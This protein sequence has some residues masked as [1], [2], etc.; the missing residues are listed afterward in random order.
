MID[1]LV[2]FVKMSGSGNDFIMIDNRA[3]LLDPD[4]LG[5]WIRAVCRRGVAVGA[6]GV[7]LVQND[8][9]GEVDFAWRFFN[10]DGGEAEMCGNGGRCV[11]RWAH[12]LGLAS[13]QTA[14]RTQVGVIRGWV[15]GGREVRVQLTEP[16]DYRA[17]VSLALPTGAI[18]AA[19]LDTGVPHAVLEVADAQAVD[20]AT[21]GRAIRM[22]DAF[23]PRGV[24]VNF[25]QITG[26]HDVVIR[27]YERG[28][29]DETLA[30][31]TGC[32]AAA[33]TLARAGR[34][35][36]PVR[37]A[38]RSGEELTVDFHAAGETV[39]DLTLQG[40][41]RYVAQGEILPEAWA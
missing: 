19:H 21:L 18:T 14:F 1:R 13:A 25:V 2:P 37:L 34:V 27:T 35:Q 17:T 30:C 31:G 3:G 39:R 33:V 7:I 4:R 6:D 40:P 26:G 29:E 28:V 15:L 36:N 16:R 11:V 9:L 8:P 5:D 20:V 41:V 32:A 12:D 38:T 23:A 10:N 24:N 22:H